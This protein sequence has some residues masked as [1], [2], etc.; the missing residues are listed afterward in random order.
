MTGS[1]ARPQVNIRLDP[2][3]A[4]ILAAVAF[5]NDAS[6]AEILR[7]VVRTFLSKQRKDPAVDAALKIRGKKRGR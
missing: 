2:D 6:A 4:E 7:P 5:L 3:E 1:V